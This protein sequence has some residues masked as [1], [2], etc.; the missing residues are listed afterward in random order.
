MRGV[1]GGEG[2]RDS[3]EALRALREAMGRDGLA[4]SHSGLP[5]WC[6][7]CAGMTC[8]YVDGLLVGPSEDVFDAKR[9]E[10]SGG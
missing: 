2:E 8:T 4:K 6:T 9:Y 10:L 5:R 1:R 7:M 3:G